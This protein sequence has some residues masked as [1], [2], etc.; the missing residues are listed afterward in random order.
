MSSNASVAP[1][2]DV[3]ARVRQIAVPA[4]ARALS[5]LSRID[6]EDAFVVDVGAVC[7]RTAEQWARAVLEDASA[8]TRRRL[9]SGWCA[10]GLKLGVA[11]A[12]RSVLGWPIRENSDEFVLLGAESRVGMAGELLFKRQ[13]DALLFATFIEQEGPVA[14]GIWAGV[15]PIHVPAV[16][17]LLERTSNRLVPGDAG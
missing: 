7:E 14:R 11:P 3:P 9:Q 1:Q 5:T 8:G 12:E 16:H 13:P 4:D 6:Y 10:I 2:L 17:R 15:Q